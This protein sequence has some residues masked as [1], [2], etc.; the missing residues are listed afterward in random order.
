MPK[1][2]PLTV[3]WKISPS[4]PALGVTT[5]AFDGVNHGFVTFLGFLGEGTKLHAEYGAYRQIAVIMECIVGI[6]FY[7]DFSSADSERLESYDWESLPEF[8]DDDGSL[9]NHVSRFHQKWA[10]T[11]VCPD[12]SVYTV[13]ESD[14]LSDLYFRSDSPPSLQFQHFLFVGD[15][16]SVEVIAK[17]YRWEIVG[18]N[19]EFSQAVPV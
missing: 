14:W 7:P 4:T 8:R 11:Q 12:P 3:P 2:K 16:Y 13:E 10:A 18:S 6:R 5:R 9:R 15:D 17:A 1:L 19:S